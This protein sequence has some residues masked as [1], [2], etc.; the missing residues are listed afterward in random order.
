[1]PTLGTRPALARLARRRHR[2]GHSAQT[3]DNNFLCPN[4]PADPGTPAQKAR[5]T[6]EVEAQGALNARSQFQQGDKPASRAN[7][8]DPLTLPPVLHKAYQ[9]PN[10]AL[11]APYA[12][13]GGKKTWKNDAERV[14]FLLELYQRI[15]SQA[16]ADKPKRRQKRA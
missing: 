3:V 13:C 2:A 15:S 7:L 8:Y 10:A 11:Y 1:M 9:K 16:H 5:A 6:I 12:L 14:A 4:L